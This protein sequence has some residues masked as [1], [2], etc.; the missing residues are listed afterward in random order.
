MMVGSRDDLGFC[1]Y[2]GKESDKVNQQLATK[3]G[4]GL[5]S[6]VANALH[7]YNLVRFFLKEKWVL[8]RH[9]KITG[10]IPVVGISFCTFFNFVFLTMIFGIAKLRRGFQFSSASTPLIDSFS[11]DS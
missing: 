1:W 4:V 9:A 2:I 3:Q 5:L 7:L 10:S 8:S 11:M 6:I